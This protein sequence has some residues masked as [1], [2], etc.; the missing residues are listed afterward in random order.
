MHNFV[1]AFKFIGRNGELPGE[2]HFPTLALLLARDAED[3]GDRDGDLARDRASGRAVARPHPPRL[4]RR[5][6]PRQHLAGA[7]EPR[8]AGDRRR[9]PGHRLKNVLLALVVLAVP[10]IVTN[11]YVG[12]DRG[13]PRYRRRGPRDGNDR[14]AA[15]AAGRA[16]AGGPAGDGRRPDRGAVRRL[17][18]DDRRADRLLP[19]ASARS[20]TTRRATTSP[21]CS[22][23]RSASPC[24]RCGRASARLGATGDDAAA[25]RH[26]GEP[27]RLEATSSRLAVEA[28]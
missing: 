14:L 7:A 17:H 5:D 8:G 11:A 18:D 13:R 20:S 26:G 27:A 4:V 1:D 22:A 21:A 6:Q 24:W 25:L 9:V 16:A 15:A 23:P 3:R 10:P 2:P 12:V 19:T 28:V